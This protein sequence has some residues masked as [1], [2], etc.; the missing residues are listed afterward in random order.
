MKTTAFAVLLL[1]CMASVA[2][3]SSLF[4]SE[5]CPFRK[6]TKA[7]EYLN[8]FFLRTFGVKANFN[9]CEGE[10]RDAY[11]MERV[12]SISKAFNDGEP[13]NV[14]SAIRLSLH[15]VFEMTFN[16]DGCEVERQKI[17]PYL[18][19]LHQ[20]E[21][22]TDLNELVQ[23]SFDELRPYEKTFNKQ[24]TKKHWKRVGEANGDIFN[25]LHKNRKF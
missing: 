3:A 10:W 2:S 16:F 7:G 14:A 17:A 11:L 24:L 1:L 8:G 25:V 21:D 19:K 6:K 23:T 20:M 15:T 13:E 4:G 5:N 22:S 18:E 9:L 12:L